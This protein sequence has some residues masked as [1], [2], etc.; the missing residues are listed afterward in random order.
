MNANYMRF[1][2]ETMADG[3]DVVSKITK[4]ERNFE[5]KTKEINLIL[6][7]KVVCDKDELLDVTIVIRIEDANNNEEIETFTIFDYGDGG[8]CSD[9]ATKRRNSER[10]YISLLAEMIKNHIELE[11]CCRGIPESYFKINIKNKLA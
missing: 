2:Y 6:D 7:K 10:L 8:L 3:S 5:Q 4:G 1:Y 9:I 11:L